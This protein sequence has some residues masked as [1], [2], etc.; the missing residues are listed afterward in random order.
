MADFLKNNFVDEYNAANADTV[1][2][3]LVPFQGLGRLEEEI[4]A[5]ARGKIGLYDAY[6][7]MPVITGNI[8][9]LGGLKDLTQFVRENSELAWSD[10]TLFHRD[11]AAVYNNKVVTLPLDGDVLLMYYRQDLL[12]EYGLDVPRTWDEYSEVAEF[13]DGKVINGTRMFGSCQGRNK[14]CAGHF[15]Q[16]CR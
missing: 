3:E 9:E 6:V 8:D 4:I 10:V 7:L 2:I 13:F 14:G 1:Q 16:E 5:D 15:R 11:V 12:D